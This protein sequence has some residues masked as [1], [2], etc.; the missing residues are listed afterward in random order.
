MIAGQYSVIVIKRVLPLC[1]GPWFDS[2]L[3]TFLY[4]VI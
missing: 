2:V 4:G 3:R 1:E